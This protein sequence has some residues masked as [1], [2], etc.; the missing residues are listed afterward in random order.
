MDGKWADDGLLAPELI[1]FFKSGDHVCINVE[2]AVIN[3]D[4]AT[5]KGEFFHAMHPG[6]VSVFNKIG[7]DIW[8]V[9]NNHTMDAG[10]EGVVSTAA[11][12]KMNGA[13]CFGAGAN[14]R[15]ASEPVYL[16]EAGGI[17]IIG[18]TYMSENNAA[19]DSQAGFFRWD[20]MDRI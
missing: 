3:V 4:D 15:E 14:V 2:G 11:Y 12:A 8:C 17:G 19:T 1:D 7:A 10:A 6:A 9:G 13:K 16:D 5:R 18:V 20:D